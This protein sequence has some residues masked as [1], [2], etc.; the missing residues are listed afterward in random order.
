MNIRC[1]SVCVGCVCVWGGV[2]VCECVCRCVCL[3]VCVEYRFIPT[4]WPH[5]RGLAY[6]WHRVPAPVAAASQAICRPRLHRAIRG[7][8][9]VLP[10]RVG[11]AT[12]QLDLPSLTLMSAAGCGRLQLG[13]LH[14]ANYCKYLIIDPTLCGSRFSSGRL[15]AI[16][17]FTFFYQE[18]HIS[19]FVAMNGDMWVRTRL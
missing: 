2:W 16:E 3:C 12:S 15:L 10:T 9:G 8:Q 1:V 4:E 13:V 7:A 17:D 5:R 19:N 11:R 6:P 14:W 18:Q